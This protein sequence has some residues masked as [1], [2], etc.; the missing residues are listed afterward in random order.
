MNT[1]QMEHYSV[2]H[3]WAYLKGLENKGKEIKDWEKKPA[4]IL[5]TQGII[6]S[7]L[8]YAIEHTWKKGK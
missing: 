1:K 3:K 5:S 4:L 7:I 8:L 2:C 6:F